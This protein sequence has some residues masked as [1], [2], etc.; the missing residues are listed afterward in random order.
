MKFASVPIFEDIKYNEDGSKQSV[1]KDELRKYSVRKLNSG[2]EL[3]VVYE[4]TCDACDASNLVKLRNTGL[5][6]DA[7]S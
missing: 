5:L 1:E 3:E 6:G 7:L 4:I 2:N